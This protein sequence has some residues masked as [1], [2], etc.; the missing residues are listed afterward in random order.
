MQK[1]CASQGCAD[2]GTEGAEPAF[3]GAGFQSLPREAA[4][5]ESGYCAD[6]QDRAWFLS[7]TRRVESGCL[8]WQGNINSTGYGRVWFRGRI[9]SAHRLAWLLFKG[10]I[11]SGLFILHAC[12]NRR[13]VDFEN[14]LRVGTA[15]E[16][17]HDAS[18]RGRL[19]R[20]GLP[21]NAGERHYKA[22]VSERDVMVMRRMAR[23]FR[24]SAGRAADAHHSRLGM[25][26][27]GLQQAIS[28][29]SWSH[30]PGGT[31][32]RHHA[33]HLASL[34]RDVYADDESDS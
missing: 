32:P 19:R 18:I 6:E 30:L 12:D 31:D 16:N 23:I 20:N 22:K 1:E 3:T 8:E 10:P 17:S 33:R 15:A 13:C 2:C 26:S 9:H 14:H 27:S 25:S 21:T 24:V 4:R 11:P 5:G 34:K 28:G 29:S 7:K